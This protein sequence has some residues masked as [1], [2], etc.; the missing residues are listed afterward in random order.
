MSP[1]DFVKTKAI[2]LQCQFALDD[3]LDDL[4]ATR[5]FIIQQEKDNPKT[6]KIIFSLPNF[7][8]R[9][10]NTLQSETFWDVHFLEIVPHAD[11]DAI[12]L[13]LQVTGVE[14]RG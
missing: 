4:Q 3:H 13:I 14:S 11:E 9:H 12:R 5:P 6:W 10:L 2:M 1:E 8:I 7:S